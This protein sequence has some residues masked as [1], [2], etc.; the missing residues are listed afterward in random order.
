MFSE[1]AKYESYNY[2]STHNH[3]NCL[4]FLDFVS[5]KHYGLPKVTCSAISYH[6]LLAVLAVGTIDGSIKMYTNSII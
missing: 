6:P 4:T 1:E 5:L 3:K 2:T